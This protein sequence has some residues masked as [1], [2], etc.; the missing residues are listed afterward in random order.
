M[1]QARFLVAA[2][3]LCLS[4]GAARGAFPQIGLEPVSQGQLIAPV[5]MTTA[6]DGS[7]R[8]FVVDQRGKIQIIQNGSLLPTPFLDIG[9]TLVSPR[10]GF[11]ERGLLGLAFHPQYAVDNAP[12][13]GKFYVYYSAPNPQTAGFDHVDTLAEYTVSAANPNLADPNS[14][15]VMLVND[16]PQFNHDGGQLAFGPDGRLYMSIGDGG[17]GGDDDNGHTGNTTG[18][19]QNPPNGFLGNA[20][21]KTK[22]MGKILRLDPLGNNSPNGQ[23]GIPS[24]N[25]FVGE[26]GGVR[27]EIW[28]YGLRNTWR[29]S[30]DDGPGGSG[31]LF[32]ADVG[33]GS[34]E[35][36]NIIEKGGNYGWRIR[37]GLHPFDATVPDPGVPLIDPINEY[38]HSQGLSVTGGYVYRG[39]DFPELTGKYIFGDWSTVFSEPGNG[40]LFGLEEVAP[41]VWQRTT[42]DVE[43]GNPIGLFI[44][45]FGEDEDGE[46]YVVARSSLGTGLNLQG[47]VGGAIF[48]ITVVPEPGTATA[49]LLAAVATLGRRRRGMRNRV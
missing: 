2:C 26:G 21:D 30:F 28:A 19:N 4:A 43:G 20:Q 1:K 47:Q 13:E 17:G 7:N 40:T 44:T 36:I 34:Y 35:E 23:Y 41:G 33:Q 31:K 5:G 14:A 45:A 29:F 46:L 6:N 18:T 22:I 39:S 16:H 32:A 3:A 25:P 27:P 8:L 42:L 49:M 38:D 48:R 37:E 12:G 11:D 9:P 10:A 24:D 15:R